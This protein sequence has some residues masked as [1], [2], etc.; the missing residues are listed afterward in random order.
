MELQQLA[1]PPGTDEGD[2]DGDDNPYTAVHLS[3][4]EDDG[5]YRSAGVNVGTADDD[6]VA[7]AIVQCVQGLAAIRG[8]GLQLALAKRITIREG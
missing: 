5:T 4:C 3:I 6:A 7:S 8:P 1:V 2:D